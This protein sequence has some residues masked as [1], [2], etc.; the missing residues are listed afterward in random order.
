LLL[1]DAGALMKHLVLV[2]LVLA[3]LSAAFAR[4]EQPLVLAV[5]AE[6]LPFCLDDRDCKIG[7]ICANDMCSGL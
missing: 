4:R 7:Q 5:R 2:C 1:S 3:A 6:A